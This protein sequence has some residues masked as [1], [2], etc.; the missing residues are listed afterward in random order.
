MDS[1]RCAESLPVDD[2]DVAAREQ[3]CA[4][5]SAV[6]DLASPAVTPDDPDTATKR[7]IMAALEGFKA[8]VE[9]EDADALAAWY[10]PGYVE[11]D[12]RTAESVRVAFKTLCQKYL[13]ETLSGAREKHGTFTAWQRPAM[14]LFIR[15][16]LDVAP[17]RVVVKCVYEFWMG[18]GPEMEPGDMFKHPLGGHEK[19][20]TVT[21]EKREDGWKIAATEPSFLRAEDVTR[22]RNR[23]PGW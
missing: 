1:A 14:R 19:D 17:Q 15:D 23:Y 21:W 7:E 4:E 18:S 22:F 20:F 5:C 16:W 12:S 8:S 9:A 11:E 2:P 13:A 3:R 6:E 10:G